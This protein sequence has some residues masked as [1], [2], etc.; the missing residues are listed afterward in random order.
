MTFAQLR[1]RCAALAVRLQRKEFGLQAGDMVALCLPN[2]ADFA[3]ACFGAMEAGLTLTTV[4]PIY[5]AGKIVVLRSTFKAHV[6]ECSALKYNCRIS[7]L[8]FMSHLWI[9]HVRFST[10]FI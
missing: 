5:T 10:E 2:S 7:F 1:D 3:I 4:N 6:I 9:K 8:H